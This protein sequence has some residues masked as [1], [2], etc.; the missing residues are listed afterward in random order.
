MKLKPTTG[1]ILVEAEI[2][3]D[4]T[5][6]GVVLPTDRAGDPKD[7][8]NIGKVL[9]VGPNMVK[10]SGLEVQMPVKVGD[11]IIFTDFHTTKGPGMNS[12]TFIIDQEDVAAIIEE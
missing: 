4:I 5:K 8:P 3:E 7:N 6:G 1:K 12:K 2:P 11:R 9:A 10:Q